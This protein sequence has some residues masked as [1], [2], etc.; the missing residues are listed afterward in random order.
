MKK[1]KEKE[2]REI[3]LQIFVAI[4]VF[5]LFLMIFFR[6]YNEVINPLE[7]KVN[8]RFA[9]I[10][11]E[12]LQK[13]ADAIGNVNQSNKTAKNVFVLTYHVISNGPPQDEYEISYDQFKENMFELK[14]LGYQTISLQDLYLFLGGEKTLPDKSFVLTFDDAAKS[15]YYNSDP[16]LKVL[17]YTAVMF[18]ITGY[19]LNGKQSAYYLNES[20]LL[21]A[22]QTG[23]WELGSHTHESH[24]RP[25]ISATNEMAPALTNKLWIP[26]ENRLETDQEFYIRISNDLKKAKEILET[27]FNISLI[28]LALPYG[29]FGERGSNYPIAQNTL[30]TLTTNMH[31][32]VFYQFPIKNKAFKANY[33][34]EKQD[35][36]VVARLPADSF[37]T[38]E[39]LL[40]RI[41]SSGALELPYYESYTNYDRWPR[42]SGE[43]SFEQNSIILKTPENSL[44]EI[45]FA[46]LDGSYLWQDY[47]YSLKLKN[48]GASTVSLLSRLTSQLDYVSCNYNQ[49]GVSLIKSTNGV[50]EKIISKKIPE[51]IRIGNGTTLSMSVSGLNSSCFINGKEILNAEI[52][53]MPIHGGV[54]IKAENFKGEDTTFAF[55][56]ISITK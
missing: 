15:G 23:R 3:T 11:Y 13:E 28:T 31:K 50:H 22:Q 7:E 43:A 37:R 42:I 18:V 25:S 47:T 49:E 6:Y 24:Y 2:S 16:I 33:P 5:A 40:Q 48:S 29:D 20:E 53:N 26:K 44:D 36:Y 51:N 35:S 55:K 34:E 30:H 41:E 45:K 38:P 1:M 14:R 4:L 52:P 54:G 8:P 17:N 12:Q 19:S 9:I 46:Y 27:R 10:D 32:L 39:K 21:S 56:E